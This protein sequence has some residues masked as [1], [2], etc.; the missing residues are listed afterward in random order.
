[1]DFGIE[2][3]GRSDRFEDGT[4]GF[5]SALTKAAVPL[6][7]MKLKEDRL[8]AK[9]GKESLAWRRFLDMRSRIPV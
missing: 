9:S 5:W 8:T 6:C 1:M 2:Q 3:V 4:N 7:H